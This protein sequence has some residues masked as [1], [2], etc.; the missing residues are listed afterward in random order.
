M[1]GK[2]D[3]TESVVQ[4]PAQITQIEA[5][6]MPKPGSKTASVRLFMSDMSRLMWEVPTTVMR[7]LMSKEHYSYLTF[8]WHGNWWLLA[9]LHNTASG[10]TGYKTCTNPGKKVHK[11]REKSPTGNFSA[12]PVWQMSLCTLNTLVRVEPEQ[13]LQDLLLSPGLRLRGLQ[14][15]IQ[16]RS[17]AKVLT[18]A[19]SCSW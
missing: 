15:H 2:F 10:A 17:D 6:A 3:R 4:P 16:A 11:Y 19:I 12:K 9:W 7:V 18:H 14:L 5:S 1:S 13:H 8:L